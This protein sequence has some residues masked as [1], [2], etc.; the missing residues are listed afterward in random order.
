MKNQEQ[1]EQQMET[2]SQE[3]Q[4]VKSRMGTLKKSVL[5]LRNLVLVFAIIV[6]IWGLAIGFRDLFDHGSNVYSD[7]AQIEQYVSPINV[8]AT[9]YIQ[10]V[11]FTEHQHVKK[12]D[13]LMV[14]DQREY[15]IQ[16]KQAEAN[17]ADART[18]GR[19]LGATIER[20]QQSTTVYD[21]SIDELKIRL[22]QLE[23]DKQRY[24]NLVSK[25]AATQYQ[26]DHIIVEYDATKQKI[27]SVRRQKAAAQTGVNEVSR[28]RGSIN[29]GLER[30]EAA[31]EQ[32]LLNLSYTVVLAPCDGQ[33]GRRIIEEGQFI[34]AGTIITN[35]IPD[36]PKWVIANYKERQIGKLHIGQKVTLTIDAIKD[37]KYTG[38]ISQIAGAT[39]SRFSAIPTDNSAGNFVKIQQRVPIR[40]EF[41]GLTQKDFYQMAAGMMVEVKAIE[42]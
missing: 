11:C 16:V 40:I 4:D 37:K 29:A 5:K 20:T 35:I 39:G 30:T 36:K 19:V 32:A 31:L 12:G 26:L 27:E 9:G 17:L 7:D 21:N 23:K 10:R 33:V 42:N 34:N 2:H 18:G 14:L 41:D 15:K 3:I 38:H 25:H 8:R 6:L 22:A 13:T 1:Q 28:R 24:E